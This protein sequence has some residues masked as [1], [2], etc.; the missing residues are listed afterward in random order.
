MFSSRNDLTSFKEILVLVLSGNGE[1]QRPCIFK[2]VL[3]TKDANITNLLKT[4][5]F[6]MLFL[7]QTKLFGFK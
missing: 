3:T 2:L 7:K 1:H 4:T 5:I 6:T